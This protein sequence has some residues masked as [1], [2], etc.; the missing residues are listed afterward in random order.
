MQWCRGM[1]DETILELRL[2]SGNNR[3][4]DVLVKDGWTLGLIGVP[5]SST[6]QSFVTSRWLSPSATFRI[7]IWRS[8]NTCEEWLESQ[9]P[10]LWWSRIGTRGNVLALTIVIGGWRSGAKK[11]VAH[12]LSSTICAGRYQIGEEHT[13]CRVMCTP[14]QSSQVK[15]NVSPPRNGTWVAVG[16]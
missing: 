14:G 16:Q 12:S 11:P 2:R 1:I 3:A 9:S 10:G 13:L 15:I 6:G 7:V 4:S 5:L 8:S